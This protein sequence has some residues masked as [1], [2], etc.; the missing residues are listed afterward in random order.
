MPE[1]ISVDELKTA[2]AMTGETYADDAMDVAVNA[3]NE[4]CDNYKR[5]TFA[6]TEDQ[7]RIY[8]AQPGATKLEIDDLNT[9]TSV[10]VDEDG[11]GVFETTWVEGTD[12]DLLPVNAP[13]EGIPYQAIGLRA[14]GS[15]ASA[16]P[17]YPNTVKVTGSY[18]WLQTPQ[19][20]VQAA[21][22]IANFLLSSTQGAPMGVLVESAGDAVAMARI[23]RIHPAAAALL[24][25]IPG[26]ATPGKQG[27]K[28]LQLG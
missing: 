20:V 24:D 28:S 13:F 18:G 12:F 14:R 9:L 22:L 21:T 8:T 15:G 17:R 5:T 23:G 11:D 2:L 1:Y 3:A 27:F 19:S 16:F 25:L 4:A 26:R 10:T 7:A 6:P